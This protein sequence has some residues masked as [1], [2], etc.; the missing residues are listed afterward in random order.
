MC[1]QC[2]IVPCSPHRWELLCTLEF[3]P[4]TFAQSRPDS[5]LSEQNVEKTGVTSRSP[6]GKEP[7]GLVQCGGPRNGLRGC[8]RQERV[9][10]KG[11]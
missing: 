8:V 2:K 6:R 1:E 4:H 7:L 11:W 10:C 3:P 9:E 5:R